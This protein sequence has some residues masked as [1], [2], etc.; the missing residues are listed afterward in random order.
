MSAYHA[1]TK[2]DMNNL[3]FLPLDDGSVSSESADP[4]FFICEFIVQMPPLVP[5]M[6]TWM[7]APPSFAELA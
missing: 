3:T 7:V 2:S 6:K 1:F 5:K 4:D